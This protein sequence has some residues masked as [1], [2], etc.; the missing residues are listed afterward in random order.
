MNKNE[1][2]IKSMNIWIF[3]FSV[4]G[5]L[6]GYMYI[7]VYDVG[8]VIWFFTLVLLYM[9]NTQKKLMTKLDA[10]ETQIAQQAKPAQ[11]PLSDQAV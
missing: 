8:L 2:V 4:I 5:V 11:E 6:L 1:K 10:L 3:V 9:I 7:G